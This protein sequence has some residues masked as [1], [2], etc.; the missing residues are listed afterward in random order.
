MAGWLIGPGAGARCSGG[1]PE[2]TD[3]DR[4]NRTDTSTA[5]RERVAV[6]ERSKARGRRDA[7]WKGRLGSRPAAEKAAQRAAR[8]GGWP[9]DPQGWGHGPDTPGRGRADKAGPLKR[10]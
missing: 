3:S 5:G 6:C 9:A 1:L 4:Q 2:R 7:R 8:R 10:A